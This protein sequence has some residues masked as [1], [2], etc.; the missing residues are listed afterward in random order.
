[1]KTKESILLIIVFAISMILASTLHGHGQSKKTPPKKATSTAAKRKTPVLRKKAIAKP[2]S[3][4]LNQA[5]EAVATSATATAPVT[6][7]AASTTNATVVNAPSTANGF[8]GASSPLG[9]LVNRLTS[10][11]ATSKKPHGSIGISATVFFKS[12][13]LAGVTIKKAFY[14][15]TFGAGLYNNPGTYQAN[16]DVVVYGGAGIK[17]KARISVGVLASVTMLSTVGYSSVGNRVELTTSKKPSIGFGVQ[18]N[19]ELRKHLWLSAT[20][21][22][23]LGTGIGATYFF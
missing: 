2:V 10:D 16:S 20:L 21:H 13:L 12:H 17:T 4:T 1:M 5:K 15:Y 23:L 3:S 7:T 8:M 14:Y 22:T 11:T 6:A 19:F 9:Y 18:G